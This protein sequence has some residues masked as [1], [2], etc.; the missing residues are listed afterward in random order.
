M[1][2]ILVVGGGVFGTTAALELARRG[3]GVTLLDPGPLPRDV[4]ASTDITKAI[5]MDY[6]R[7]ERYMRMAEEA[8]A[9]WDRWNERWGESLYH[10]DGFLFLSSA[11]MAPG[12]FEH[13]SFELLLKRGHR[14]E[15]LDANALAAKH[16]DWAPGR[17]VDGYFNPR[18]GWA[19]SGR[20]V[21]KLVE[22]ARAAG[23]EVR[24][25][26]KL[27]RLREQGSRVRGVETADGNAIDA[28]LVL[29]AAGAWTPSLLPHLAS[30]M[31]I[32]GQPVL[33]F[34]P[35]DPDRYRP[36]S[37][38]PFAADLQ[39]KGWYGF[40]ATKKGI[41]KIAHHGRG[42]VIHPDAPRVVGPEHEARFRA[43]LRESIPS[44]ADAPLAG[45]RLCLYCDT[46]DGNFWIDHDPER[47]GLV[48]A[49]GGSGHGF[50]FAPV[51][52]GVIA[53]VVERRAN[54]Y[55]PRFAWRARGTTTTEHARHTES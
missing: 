33:H 2:R 3:H 49:A 19:E 9:G 7:D 23:V 6:G 16:P 51:L 15:R 28:D 17:Y 48:V 50:K 27:S 18:A 32:V 26:V 45:S 8:L 21:E 13:D 24:E 29:V 36:P 47:E 53:D 55:A 46:W 38:R 41:V 40:P 14:P 25:G 39:A 52:G 42:I 1:D 37:F 31:E 34:A 44:L 22:E 12:G 11:P 54:A 5:R 35:A 30:V 10:E 43:F 20:V 4:A